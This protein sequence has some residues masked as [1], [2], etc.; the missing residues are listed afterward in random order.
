MNKP[1]TTNVV[2]LRTAAQNAAHFGHYKEAQGI[3][4]R[5]LRL[6]ENAYGKDSTEYAE[7]LTEAGSV[8][9]PGWK[10]AANQ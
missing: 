7:C 4:Q 6:V 10:E 9:N 1:N 2:V 5:L 3:Y 8:L